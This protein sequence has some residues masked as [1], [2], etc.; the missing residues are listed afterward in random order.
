MVIIID[1]GL[2]LQFS[3]TTASKETLVYH[4][5]GFYFIFRCTSGTRSFHTRDSPEDTEL[6][7][8][9]KSCHEKSEGTT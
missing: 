4:T 6:F 5:K 3:R 9:L 8:P 1:V 2:K 7:K